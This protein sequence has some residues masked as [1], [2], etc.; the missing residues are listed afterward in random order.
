MNC[1]EVV[2]LLEQYV[3]RELNSEEIDE[4][5]R[6]LDACPP[7]LTLFHFEANMRRLV[8]RACNESAPDSLRERILSQRG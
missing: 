6:H 8:R 3:D 4:V 1:I 7:C 5:R 2:N